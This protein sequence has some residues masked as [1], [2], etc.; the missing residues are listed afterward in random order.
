MIYNNYEIFPIAILFIERNKIFT[1]FNEYLNTTGKWNFE[2]N[3]LDFSKVTSPPEI[4]GY[5]PKLVMWTPSNN[6]DITVIFSNVG[7]GY[8]NPINNFCIAHNI[9]VIDVTFNGLD[10]NSNS[11]KYKFRYGKVVD[12]KQEERVLQYIKDIGWEYYERGKKLDF[13][14]QSDFAHYHL[15]NEILIEYLNH[16]NI[17][18]NEFFF[19]SFEEAY[20]FEQYEWRDVDIDAE[21]DEILENIN[22]KNKRG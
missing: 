1:S 7:D 10:K 5:Y 19:N 16:F 21:V 8:T 17:T 15:T 12:G 11:G 14:N 9:E 4:K 2:I 13:E 18:I 20:Y 22:K 6:K 3:K